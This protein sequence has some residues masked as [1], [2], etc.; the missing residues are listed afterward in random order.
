MPKVSEDYF[1]TKKN[2]ILD[3]AFNVC[4]K[5]PVYNVVMKD[6]VKESGL[7]QGGVYKYF[8]NIDDVLIALINRANNKL[9]IKDDIDRILSSNKSHKDILSEVFELIQNHMINSFVEYGKIF[10]EL[11]LVFANEPE[12]YKN[13]QSKIKVVPELIYLLLNFK[14]Y[15]EKEVELGHIKP[16]LPIEDIIQFMITSINGILQEIIVTKCYQTTMA[17]GYNMKLDEIKLIHI[18]YISVLNLLNVK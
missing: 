7:S 8:S 16:I 12:R 1:E 2:S 11:T 13:T 14:T 17:S 4:K 15:F 18:L 6:V 5:K 10:F 9:T 3:A